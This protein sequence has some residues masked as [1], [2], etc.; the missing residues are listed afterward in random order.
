VRRDTAVAARGLG[1]KPSARL[2][3]GMR[4]APSGRMPHR[5]KWTLVDPP[6]RKPRGKVRELL[7]A[8]AVAIGSVVAVGPLAACNYKGCRYDEGGC[9]E[10][11]DFT[12]PDLAP[13][14]LG[15]PSDLAKGAGDGGEE[16]D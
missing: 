16:H 7:R 14:D 11:P 6:P 5:P 15:A 8:G 2:Q 1:R 12:V 3:D 13:G 4:V 9:Y 10:R